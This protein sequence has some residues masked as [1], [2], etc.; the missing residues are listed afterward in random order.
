LHAQKHDKYDEHDE[1]KQPSTSEQLLWV[2]CPHAVGCP[3]ADAGCP[4]WQDGPEKFSFAPLPLFPLLQ[5]RVA[6]VARTKADARTHTLVIVL[7][8]NLLGGTSSLEGSSPFFIGRQKGRL[9]IDT[10]RPA[11]EVGYGLRS[12]CWLA[13]ARQGGGW[14]SA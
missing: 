1:V 14:A 13:T 2:H 10:F 12:A 4:P 5:A 9:Q 6:P 11:S 3:D 7:I 8:A